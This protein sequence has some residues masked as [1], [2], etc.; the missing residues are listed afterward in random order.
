MALRTFTSLS[1]PL[2]PLPSGILPRDLYPFHTRVER[3][4]AAR[5]ATLPW[6]V[7]AFVAHNTGTHQ[8]VLEQMVVPVRLALK[9]DTQVMLVKNVNERLVN[10]SVGRVL[11]FFMLAAY[12]VGILA[13]TSRARRT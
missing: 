7:R 12:A 1:F 3:A 6:A 13:S 8:K 4:N 10:G 2:H 5:L 9:A 11:G